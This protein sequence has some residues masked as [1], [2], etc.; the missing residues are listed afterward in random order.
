MYSVEV[1]VC[2]IVKAYKNPLAELVQR[3][4]ECDSKVTLSNG[5]KCINAKSIMGVLAFQPSE[6]M[7]VRVSADGV[8]EQ[9]A[10]E[11]MTRFLSCRA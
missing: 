11:K 7:R 9:M 3:A 10:V 8:D 6:G 4:C 5:G 2:N 1:T